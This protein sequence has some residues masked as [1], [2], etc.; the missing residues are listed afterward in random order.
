MVGKRLVN[1][2]AASAAIDPLQNFESVAYRGSAGTQKIT[3]YIRKGAAFDGTN[4]KITTSYNAL[5]NDFSISFWIKINDVSYFQVLLGTTDSYAAQEGL[6]IFYNSSLNTI[7]FDGNINGTRINSQTGSYQ[8]TQNQWHHVVFTNNSS[9]NEKILYIDNGVQVS[10]TSLG[11][12][13]GQT[14]DLVLGSYNGYTNNRLNGSIDQFRIFNKALSSSEVATLYGETYASTTKSTVDIFGDSS[15][16]ALYELDENANDTGGNYNATP[17]SIKFLGTAFQPDLVWMKKRSNT[18][19][20]D[21]FL[22]DSVRGSNKFIFP[23]LTA[24]EGTS[25]NY[26]SS[27]DTNG[28][29]VPNNVYT[30]ENGSNFI[31]WCWKAGGTAVSNTDGSITSSVSANQDAGF[32]IVKWTG[33]NSTATIGHG[34]SSAPEI[35]I[36][37]RL[38]G[39]SNWA[40]DTTVIDG[41]FDYLFLDTT[42]AKADH[43]TLTAPTSA[44]F[45]T[46][47]SNFNAS[48]MIAYCF[49]SVD[50]YQKIGYYTSNASVKI[51][52]GFEPRWIIIKY[53]GV[54]NDWWIMDIERYGGATGSHGGKLVTSYLEA[55]TLSPEQS[56]ASGSVEFVSDGFYPT[57][58][59][60]SNGV[61]YLAIA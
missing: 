53:T 18:Q 31:A 55:N 28:F 19:Y 14:Y 46:G 51:T 38:D 5:F 9:N 37:K 3:G 45:S 59:F 44:V 22:Y 15:G 29:T 32:S 17:T 43:S 40:F 36:R 57:N 26:F 42:A 25:T 49:H 20:S 16:T 11:Y 13:D 7:G 30:N 10:N 2:G 61:I 47:G 23:N 8:I 34:L 60:N 35:V 50:G 39:A 54:A 56:V 41:S 27:F 58:F 52:T 4:S 21:H 12:I 24:A 48:S 1:T 33:D 6:G